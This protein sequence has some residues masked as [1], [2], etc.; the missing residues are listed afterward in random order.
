MPLSHGPG[1]FSFHRS[2]A[3]YF[4]GCQDD[5]IW[6]Q[7]RERAGDAAW[8]KAPLPRVLPGG[9]LPGTALPRHCQAAVRNRLKID[10][11]QGWEV[12][13]CGWKTSG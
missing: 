6:G 10:W 7:A 2:R 12:I 3:S 8:A 5:K 11:D 13:T 9:S 4:R 1:I